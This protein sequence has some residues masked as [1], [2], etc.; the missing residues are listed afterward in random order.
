M[1][2]DIKLQKLLNILYVNKSEVYVLSS[3]YPIHYIMLYII[4]FIIIVYS[5]FYLLAIYSKY[6]QPV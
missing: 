1:N 2:K 4:I 3:Q 6:I 5:I